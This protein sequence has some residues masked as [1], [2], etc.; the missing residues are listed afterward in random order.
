MFSSAR[1]LCSLAKTGLLIRSSK[2][3]CFFSLKAETCK[4]FD[5]I[6]DCNNHLSL[7]DGIRFNQIRSGIR[8]AL[9]PAGL[10]VIALPHTQVPDQRSGLADPFLSTVDVHVYQ[11][12][13]Q[14]HYEETAACQQGSEGE[15]ECA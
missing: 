11:L 15:I 13:H 8:D 6:R 14:V 1:V 4:G 2:L 10:A 9:L 7:F 5:I 12:L 3:W